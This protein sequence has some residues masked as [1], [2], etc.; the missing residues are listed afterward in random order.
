RWVGGGGCGRGGGDESAPDSAARCALRR[1]QSGSGQICC[2]AVG[3]LYCRGAAAALGNHAGDT[4]EGANCD[5]ERWPPQLMRAADRYVA[6][7]RRARHDYFIEDTLEAGVVFQGTEVKVLRQ[8][9]T[10]IAP[11][12]AGG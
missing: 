2:I 10:T 4:G 5:A 6:Q 12:Y 9:Q 8:R 7:N 11:A 3:T 1:K